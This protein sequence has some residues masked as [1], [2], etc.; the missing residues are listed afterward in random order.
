MFV[1]CGERVLAFQ[2]RNGI[3]FMAPDETDVYLGLFLTFLKND[4]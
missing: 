4:E 1:I 3:I 2:F